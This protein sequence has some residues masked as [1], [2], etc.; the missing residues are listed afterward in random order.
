MVKATVAQTHDAPVTT[1]TGTAAQRVGQTTNAATASAL[2][3]V[4]AA[5]IAS[6]VEVALKA[7]E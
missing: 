2:A 3:S 1:S 5:T 7:G 4:A 6:R